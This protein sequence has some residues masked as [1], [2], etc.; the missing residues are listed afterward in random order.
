MD[1]PL[2]QVC[3]K[4]QR[5]AGWCSPSSACPS[6]LFVT[7]LSLDVS[8]SPLLL[9]VCFFHIFPS[10]SD[11][12]VHLPVGLAKK[13]LDLLRHHLLPVVPRKCRGWSYDQYCVFTEMFVLRQISEIHRRENT[14]K[15]HHKADQKE[16]NKRCQKHSKTS[17]S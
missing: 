8:P 5:E 15:A 3:I 4:P 17:E 7:F 11:L 13:G 2:K 6:Q 1:N 16:H 12:I 14:V 10:L 9:W